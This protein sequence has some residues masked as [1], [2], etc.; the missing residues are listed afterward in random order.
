[1]LI[2]LLCFDE[3]QGGPGT[4]ISRF[5]GKETVPPPKGALPE[6]AA[7]IEPN[8]GRNLK[9]QE[10]VTCKNKCLK[11]QCHAIWHL[12]ENLEGVLPSIEFQN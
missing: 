4:P 1:M 7:E 2:I 5:T 10:T 11:G 3:D 6:R 8:W 9:L 12:Y